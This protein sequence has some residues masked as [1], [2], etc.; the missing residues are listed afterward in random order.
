MMLIYSSAILRIID[1]RNSPQI[2]GRL[3][4]KK[5]VSKQ[6]IIALEEHIYRFSL[7]ALDYYYN[8]KT[9]EHKE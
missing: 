7:A 5:K 4:K 8:I 3:L 9:T 2:A 1:F 6:E